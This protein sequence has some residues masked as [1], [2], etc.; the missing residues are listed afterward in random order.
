MIIGYTEWDLRMTGRRENSQVID[1]ICA[2][3]CVNI[4]NH[5]ME[6]CWKAR[7]QESVYGKRWRLR[8]ISKHNL[9]NNIPRWK[10]NK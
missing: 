10:V 4:H 5:E 6:D 1:L 8:E 2:L 7:H 9:G 3:R